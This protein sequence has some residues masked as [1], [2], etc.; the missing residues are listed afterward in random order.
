MLIPAI[1]RKNEILEAFKRYYYSEEMMYETGGLGNWLPNI[2]EESEI[3]RF[4]YAIV[5]ISE[6]LLGYLDYHIDWYSSCASRFG[7]ISFNRGNPIVGKDLFNELNKLIYDYKLHRIEWRMIGGNPVERSY[8]KFC[9]K[10]GGTKH[11]LHDVI[12]DKYGKY[13]DDII[14]EIIMEK[15]NGRK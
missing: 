9:M 13:H 4:Q 5:D 10:H 8:D 14:Y 1:L 3:G 12:K 15:N 7:L 6:K 2:Q 11:V